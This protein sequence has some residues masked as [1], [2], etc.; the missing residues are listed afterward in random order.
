MDRNNPIET[1]DCKVGLAF[2]DSPVLNPG[3]VVIISE[4]FMT[5]VTL[6]FTKFSKSGS[7]S[8]QRFL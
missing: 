1:P 6:G 8:L 5:T 2:F 3:E 7:N 4:I